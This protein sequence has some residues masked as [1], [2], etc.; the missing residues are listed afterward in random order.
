M[1]QGNQQTRKEKQRDWV[2]IR[3]KRVSL[4]KREHK[5]CDQ[6]CIFKCSIQETSSSEVFSVEKKKNKKKALRNVVR[7]KSTTANPPQNTQEQE[8]YVRAHQ[9]SKTGKTGLFQ[10]FRPIICT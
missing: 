2:G 9:T 10:C 1:R 3:L 7:T 4:T 5:D 6:P 8:P